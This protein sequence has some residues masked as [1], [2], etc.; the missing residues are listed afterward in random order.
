MN[1]LQTEILAQFQKEIFRSVT[2]LFYIIVK[3]GFQ[4]LDSYVIDSK[5][6]WEFQGKLNDVGKENNVSLTCPPSGIKDANIHAKK[7]AAD[8]SCITRMY[9]YKKVFLGEEKAEKEIQWLYYP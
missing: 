5:L 9:I 8:S 2:L 4:A 3:H 7:S 1:V 6:I